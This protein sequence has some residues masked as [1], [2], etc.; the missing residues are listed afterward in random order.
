MW[1][2]R[3]HWKPRNTS[4][5]AVAYNLQVLRTCVSCCAVLTIPNMTLQV[6]VL[7]KGAVGPTKRR[8]RN[9]ELTPCLASPFREVQCR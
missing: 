9:T 6:P 5:D 3:W 1:G 7:D 8:A 2:K 4:Q